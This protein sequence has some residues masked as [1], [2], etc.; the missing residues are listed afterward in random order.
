M[1]VYTAHMVR[2]HNKQLTPGIVLMGLQMTYNYCASQKKRKKEKDRE[3]MR[4][5]KDIS[6]PFIKTYYFVFYG[7]VILSIS[8]FVIA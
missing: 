7:I 5:E 6:I 1:S 8:N 4:R 2:S 3:E